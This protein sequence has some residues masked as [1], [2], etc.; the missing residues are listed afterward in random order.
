MMLADGNWSRDVGTN[1]FIYSMFLRVD[2][3]EPHFEIWVCLADSARKYKRYRKTSVSN[4]LVA[5][6]NHATLSTQCPACSGQ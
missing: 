4:T 5:C 6:K 1:L 2:G 3:L